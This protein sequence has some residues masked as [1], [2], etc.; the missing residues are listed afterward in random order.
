MW[1]QRRV[2]RFSSAAVK[3]TSATTSSHTCQM[4]P[5]CVSLHPDQTVWSC[6]FVCVCFR[7]YVF[8]HMVF[9]CLCTCAMGFVCVCLCVFVYVCLFVCFWIC[10]ILCLC[11]CIHLFLSVSDQS[12]A[13]W[14]H[15]VEPAHLLPAAFRR[16]DRHPAHHN[17]DVPTPETSVWTCRHR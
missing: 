8:V 16:V 6:V 11:V 15:R 4:L 13:P 10:V 12:S 3:E 5:D 14:R 7:L 17:L 9:M 2:L 1:P